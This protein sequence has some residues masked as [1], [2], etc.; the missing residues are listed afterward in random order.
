[1]LHRAVEEHQCD[2]RAI[3]IRRPGC[4]RFS[5]DLSDASGWLDPHRTDDDRASTSLIGDDQDHP[6]T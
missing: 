6:L 4:F 5:A 3:A 2:R 1:M